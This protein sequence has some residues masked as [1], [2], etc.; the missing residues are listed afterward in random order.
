MKFINLFITSYLL[1]CLSGLLYAQSKSEL[2]KIELNACPFEG[3]QFGQWIC[4]DTIKVYEN[5]GDTTSIK[6]LLTENDTITSLF[7]NVHYE[8]F[9]KVLI[10]ESFGDFAINDTLIVLRCTEG[11]FSAYYKGKIIYTDI[12]WSRKSFESSDIKEVY[13]KSK[14]K[15][16]MLVPPEIVWWVKIKKN[17]IE[18]WL[19][20]KN[21]TP[22]CFRIKERIEGMDSL[23]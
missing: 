5:E 1:L 17:G 8:Q 2:S 7:G 23:S 10:T 21:L 15:G 22:Y 18:G 3:C 16:I 13:D 6:Y 11:E 14:H 4:R 9:G 19:R 20:L 12:F